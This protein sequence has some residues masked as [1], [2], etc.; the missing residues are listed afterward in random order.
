LIKIKYAD[1]SWE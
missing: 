1:R